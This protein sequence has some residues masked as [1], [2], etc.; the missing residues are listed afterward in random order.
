[1]TTTPDYVPGLAGIPAARSG[2]SNIDGNKGLLSYRG[3]R[4]EELSRES[5]FPEVAWLLLHG[6]LPT[7]RELGDFRL[8]LAEARALP[9]KVFEVIRALPGA[10]HPM[11][12][13]Q[14]SLAALG[15]SR[16][17][18]DHKDPELK[19][20]AI[21]RLLA[22]TPV[23]VAA[24]ERMRR[25][26]DLVPPDPELDTAENF[27]WMVTGEKPDPLSA[28]V[29]DVA[30]ILHADHTMNASTFTARVVA[31][32]EADPYTVVTSAVGSLTGPLH[33]GANER[34]LAQLEDIGEVD[35]VEAWVDA[36]LLEKKK[37]M[38]F[39]HRVYKVKDPRAEILQ[40]LASELFDA[41]GAT[42]IYEVALRLE[43][44]MEDRVG[45]KGI[46]PNVDFYSGIVYAKLGIPTDLFTPVFAI[47]RTAGWLAH[48]LEQMPDNR[49]FRPTQIYTGESGRSYRA[50]DARG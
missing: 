40:G 30:L 31:S 26:E 27:L 49:I 21:A 18:K 37:V 3:Y 5:T 16:R 19:A 41:L 2:I 9:E 24:F 23:M 47:A 36:R 48:W 11:D 46:Y 38:G 4:I 14:A 10:G 6:E 7:S 35:K 12:A 17:H 22:G 28:R 8:S 20:R 13:L 50:L 39:G 29:L 25:G 42:P 44:V 32:T 34:V 33:G 45:H 1:V 43:E 15:M